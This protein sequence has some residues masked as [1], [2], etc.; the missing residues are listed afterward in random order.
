[1][2]SETFPNILYLHTNPRAEKE[3]QVF[4]LFF[5]IHHSFDA[6]WK[7]LTLRRM[8][9]VIPYWTYFRPEGLPQNEPHFIPDPGFEDMVVT[10]DHEFKLIR[11]HCDLIEL[12]T[13]IK[14]P[15]DV[16]VGA[17]DRLAGR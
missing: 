2:Q 15:I 4:Y 17:M 11:S 5:G 7:Q 16:L 13:E 12:M 8:G 3:K 6:K 1:M 9:K 10:A 14:A